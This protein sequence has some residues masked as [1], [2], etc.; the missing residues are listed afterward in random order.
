VL[1]A[2]LKEPGRIEVCETGTPR[3][4]PGEVLVKVSSALTCGTDLKAFLRGHS[5][6]PMPGPF[7]HEYSGVIAEKGRG[8][9]RFKVGDA[10]M[11][12]HSAPCLKCPAC[13]GKRYNLCENIMTTKVLGAFAEYLLIP[14]HI[15]GQNLF[16][17]PD[18]LSF[19]EAAFL[20]PLACVVHAM[21][22]LGIKRQDTV[23]IIG[24]G[25][26]GLLH[27]LIARS[28]GARVLMTGLEEERLRTA[29]ALGAFAVFHPSLIAESVSAVTDGM[30]VDY[31]FECT[32]QPQV[33]ETSVD[34]V[35][36]GGT[37][38]L[39]GGCRKGTTV[40][41]DTERLH[42]DEITLKGT[43]HFTPGDV[44]KAYLLLKNRKIDVR[45]LIT[46]VYSLN[47]V[48][49]A[50]SRLSCGEGIK[51]VIQP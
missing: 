47:R 10:V 36:R 7:G 21:G 26:I 22:P 32:G 33:W 48:Q 18:N 14:E 41:F 37:V 42:Y 20:E 30:G 27:L 6:I 38:V 40:N 43:F 13:R 25:P 15:V 34:Y 17:K 12:V 23:L 46:G 39:F 16:K 11:G 35:R 51:Y 9:K 4:A 45:G 29:K 3:P 1:A 44:R 28:L 50:F 49:D 2:V 5:L 19:D 24:S 31:V 8:V